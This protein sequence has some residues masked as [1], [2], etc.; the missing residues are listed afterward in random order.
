[1]LLNKESHIFQCGPLSIYIFSDALC[2]ISLPMFIKIICN[3]TLSVENKPDFN[4]KDLL[5]LLYI[6]FYLL[7]SHT[8]IHMCHYWHRTKVP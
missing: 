8:R 2:F 1:M 6:L 3:K 7:F 5:C 4:F